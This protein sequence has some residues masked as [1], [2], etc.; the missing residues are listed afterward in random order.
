MLNYS[1]KNLKERLVDRKNWFKDSIDELQNTKIIYV[2]P[3]NGIEVKSQPI[4]G[5][6]GNKYI[7]YQEIKEYYDYGFSL[8]VYNHRDRKPHKEYIKRF[9]QIQD[10]IENKLFYLRFSR[11]SVRD[12]LF[13]SQNDI[14]EDIYA[15]LC[16]FV[17]SS[18][19]ECFSL[20][21]VDF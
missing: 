7:S 8:I 17:K 5:I 10:E 20:H 15:F 16:E 11:Y 13:V 4:G 2:D 3:D 14:A 18:W 19:G 1:Q 21:N 9:K 6:N 12:Y